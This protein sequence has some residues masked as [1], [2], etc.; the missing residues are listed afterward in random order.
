MLS[1]CDCCLISLQRPF[2]I[3]FFELFLLLVFLI[4]CF[5]FIIFRRVGIFYFLACV[6]FLASCDVEI[7][8]KVCFKAFQ[9]GPK[10]G[11]GI[12]Q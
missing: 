5:C 10:C 6:W 12:C 1:I 2:R 11:K 3:L 4:L 9:R 8:N 7:L